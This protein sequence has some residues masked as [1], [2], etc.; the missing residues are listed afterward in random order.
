[1]T[2]RSAFAFPY[3]YLATDLSAPLPF[4]NNAQLFAPARLKVTHVSTLLAD[5]APRSRLDV[6]PAALGCACQSCTSISWLPCGGSN[7]IDIDIHDQSACVDIFLRPLRAI[8][9]DRCCDESGT[10]YLLLWLSRRLGP[11]MT[12]DLALHSRDLF[13]V[14]DSPCTWCA[15][16]ANGLVVWM[17]SCLVSCLEECNLPHS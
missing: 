14:V 1:V 8:R 5:C 16:M 2:Q 3:E 13:Q 15:D 12:I 10:S 7:G 17:V 4:T 6:K 11:S 9:G